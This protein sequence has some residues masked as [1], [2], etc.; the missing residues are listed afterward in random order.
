MLRKKQQLL[1]PFF[2]VSAPQQSSFK[3]EKSEKEGEK[4]GE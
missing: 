2:S 4:E 3:R 1:C